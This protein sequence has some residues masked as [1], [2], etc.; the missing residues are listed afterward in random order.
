[1]GHI[2]SRVSKA[3]NEYLVG[4]PGCPGDGSL[5]ECPLVQM[6]K[7]HTNHYYLA[8]VQWWPE[9]TPDYKK[10]AEIV[11]AQGGKN[12]TVE[13][14]MIDEVN[15]EFDGRGPCG[16]T[17][18]VHFTAE[19]DDTPP[20]VFDLEAHLIRQHAFSL[21]TFG[22]GARTA[23]VIDHIRKELKEIAADPSDIMEWV[24]VIILAFDGAWRAGWQPEDIVKA[25]VAKQTKNE[26]RKWPDW[27]T[28]NPDKAIEHERATRSRRHRS[29]RAAIHHHRRGL[30]MNEYIK[31]LGYKAKD[32]VTGFEGVA[33]SVCFDLYGCVQ[34]VLTPQIG[35]DGKPGESQWFDAKRLTVTSTEPVMAAPAYASL[36][37]GAEI[38]P[39]EKPAFPSRAPQVR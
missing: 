1:M 30:P 22:P 19:G 37:P 8:A 3:L 6:S 11:R 4:G 29:R 20:P 25:I 10:V 21:K 12:I 16:A 18:T 27:R 28:A 9:T 32:Q 15:D 5:G 36:R 7:G 13:H 24:D 14:V 34:V 35:A 23:G 31:L 2:L 39:A 26:A 38:G 33:A 17:L